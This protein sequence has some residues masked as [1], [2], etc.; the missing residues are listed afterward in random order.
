MPLVSVV[1]PVYNG[2]KTIRYTIES[3]LNQTLSDLELIVI[4]DGSQDS[5]LEIVLSIKDLRLKVFSYPN[6]GLSASRNRG[7]AQASSDYISFIDADDLWTA[8]K[9]E[10]QFKALQANPEAVVAY[11][12]TDFIDEAGEFLRRGCHLTLNGDVYANLLLVNFLE[13]GSNML[14]RRQVFTEVG[15]FDESLKAGEDWDMYIRL[16]KRYHFVAVPS[17]QILYRISANSMSANYKRQEAACLQVIEKAFNQ[18][19]E[20]L[21]YLKKYSL[22]NLY[23]YYTFRVLEGAMARRRGLL[24]AEFFLRF[25][26]YDLELLKK[27]FTWKVLL[28]IVLWIFLSPQWVQFLIKTKFKTLSYINSDLLFCI[29]L[30]LSDIRKLS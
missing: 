6:G 10:A 24:A 2:E 8:D 17:P 13:N 1:I 7:I 22:G 26:V 27:R 4:N 19:P 25:I 18:A 29:K 23:K 14:I 28:K 20:S 30:T 9:L 21:K 5:T 16:A 3:V 11:S 15:E 12:W